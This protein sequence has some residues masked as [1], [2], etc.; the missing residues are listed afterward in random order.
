[1]NFLPIS[2]EKAFM[3]LAISE[4]SRAAEYSFINIIRVDASKLSRL[5][6]PGVVHVIQALDENKNAMAMVTEPLFASVANALGI[7]DNISKVPKELQGMV[8]ISK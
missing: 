7:L 3:S 4:L 8:G 6:H 5:R 1:M 2:S